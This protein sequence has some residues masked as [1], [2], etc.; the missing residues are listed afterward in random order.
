MEFRNNKGYVMTDM[1]I[2]VIIL[3]ILVPT[4]MGLVY[5]IGINKRATES[6]SEA[7]NIAVN[8]IEAAKGISLEDLNEQKILE[9]LDTNNEIYHYT[10]TDKNF[11]NKEGTIETE[12][13]SYKLLINVEDFANNENAPENVT[14]NVIK[15]VKATVN[16]RLRGEDQEI[17]LSTVVK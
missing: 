14:P 3:L 10:F 12:K 4:I 8:A 1:S 6:K 13:A 16:Y 7:I 5:N 11:V 2:A 15:T 9:F 17:E